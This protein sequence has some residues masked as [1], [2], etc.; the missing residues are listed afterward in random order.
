MVK[1]SAVAMPPS[2]NDMLEVSL[3]V[4]WRWELVFQEV[5]Q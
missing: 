1:V 5:F 3:V 4:T 2:V